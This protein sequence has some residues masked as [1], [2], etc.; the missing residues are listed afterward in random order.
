MGYVSYLTDPGGGA[1][2]PQ[3]QSLL[4]PKQLN[5]AV[6][7]IKKLWAGIKSVNEWLDT[8]A[9]AVPSELSEKRA[10]VCVACPMNGVGDWSQW[11]TAPA[12]AAVKRQLEKVQDRKLSTTQDDKINICEACMCPLK[13]IVHVP[14]EIKLKNMSPETKAEL[15]PSCWQLSEE[16]ELQ[17]A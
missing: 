8:N 11:Y 12:S 2:F 10:A 9:P 13:L 16:K 17:P 7:G 5:A 1:N 15:H 6:S 14:I 4:N 3:A